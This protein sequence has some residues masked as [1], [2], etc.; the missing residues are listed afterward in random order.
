VKI[1]Y[2]KK[3]ISLTCLLFVLILTIYFSYIK[4]G[5]WSVGIYAGQSP[6]SIKPGYNGTNNPVVSANDVI[7]IE[8]TGVADPF[9]LNVLEKYYLFF[10]I[11][12][13]DKKVGAIGLATSV[14]GI[15]WV[16]EKKVLEEKFHLSYPY[17]F[18]D[19]GKYYMIP[20][21]NAANGV[22][23]YS[24]VEFPLNWKFEKEIIKGSYSDSSLCYHDGKY[25]IFTFNTKDKSLY[26]F[27]SDSLMG[28]WVSHPANPI[29]SNNLN[30]ARPGGRV[31]KM[32]NTIVRFAQDDEPDYG[33]SVRAFTVNRMTV[34][35]YQESELAESPIL[36]GTGSGWNRDGM[37]HVDVIQLNNSLW[38]A[39]VDGKK[40]IN[41]FDPI[42]RY[43]KIKSWIKHSLHQLFKQ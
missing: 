21:S 24:A 3:I 5:I 30:T 23:L 7:D 19:S 28:N 14:D 2:K 34:S 4:Y 22:R 27:H 15:S 35:E 31:F 1:D 26:L 9:L 33:N 16:Y 37:H 20:E 12:T 38:I 42:R 11:I 41:V 6:L 32:G 29:I 36:T 40:Y 18:V 10:E 25:W 8:S 17:T 13:K 39:A 43:E